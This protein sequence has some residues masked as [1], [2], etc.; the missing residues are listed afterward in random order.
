MLPK[1]ALYAGIGVAGLEVIPPVLTAIAAGLASLPAL[2]IGA[3]GAMA[4]IG[5]GT[6]GIGAAISQVFNPPAGG[7]GGSS[8]GGNPYAAADH[9]DQV[10]SA[11]RSLTLAQ[12]ASADAQKNL[13]DAREQAVNDLIDMNLQLA[14][15]H[16]DEQGA[17]LAVKQAEVDLA[18]ARNTTT[19]PL[20]QEEAKQNLLEA[21]QSLKE[22]KQ[23][24]IELQQ[25]TTEANA[26]GVE[27]S[28]KVKSALEQQQN[29]VYQVADAQS[30]L[31]RANE[32]TATSAGG[33]VSALSKLAPNARAFVEEIA[34]LKPQLVDLQQYVQ[35]ELFAGMDKKLAEWAGVW[36]PTLKTDLGGLADATNGLVKRLGDDLSKPEVRQAVD[37]VFASM[38]RV[39]TKFTT[40]GALDKLVT[41]FTDLVRAATPFVEKI[42]DRIVDELGK[43]GDWLDDKSKSGAMSKF[44]E[45]AYHDASDL[46]GITK[47][48]F[49]IVSDLIDIATGRE[50]AKNGNALDSFKDTLDQVR[51]W[52][53][54]D[55][56][57]KTISDVIDDLHEVASAAITI[58]TDIAKVIAW[59]TNLQ[60]TGHQMRMDLVGV[61]DDVRDAAKFDF[62]TLEAVILNALD[63]IVTGADKAFGW[64]PGIGGK[65]DAA[66][67]K[68]DGWVG[69]VNADIDNIKSNKTLTFEVVTKGDTKLV[70][71]QGTWTRSGTNV[72]F[73][74]YGAVDA[75]AGGGITPG[76]YSSTSG[77][78]KFAEPETGGEL[79]MPRKSSDAARQQALA[80]VAA[81][82]AGGTFAT[83]HGGA[84]GASSN[85]P[86][87]TVLQPIYLGD[88]PLA[89][90]VLG[91][92]NG[93]PRVIS[94]TAAQGNRQRAYTN[95]RAKASG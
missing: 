81:T 93:A 20:A 8:G 44:F 29:A 30:A 46:W 34:K 22:A 76:I 68:F 69:G 73:N 57:K 65:L 95:V 89:N 4:M 25:S 61:F 67:K 47:D 45:D 40:G 64:I 85:A 9:A 13:N 94:A 72:K 82:W 32:Q 23:H 87:P 90:L 16:L 49:G 2:A 11:E 18:N 7:G 77:L 75:F 10:A 21:Q 56:G 19:D 54:S 63:S 66:K 48:V 39:L 5:L 79:Y 50:K 35:N 37:G 38:D 27:G 91:I 28:D 14:R 80:G 51:S 86:A 31:R 58:T 52:M 15:S 83:G 74:R 62:L 84:V 88:Q 71:N 92:V 26:K 17:I 59:F 1:I 41:G 3:A 42:G 6:H 53:E 36:I 60:K 70:D 43:L 78:L 33:A 24:T 12:R 55:K